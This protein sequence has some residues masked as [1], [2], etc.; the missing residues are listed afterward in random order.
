[1][2]SSLNTQT[3]LDQVDDYLDPTIERNQVGIHIISDDM[4]ATQLPGFNL[5]PTMVLTLILHQSYS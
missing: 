5:P 1:M 4:D 2:D 3:L